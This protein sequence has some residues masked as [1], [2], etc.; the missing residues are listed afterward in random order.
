MRD[1]ATT[2]EAAIFR[3]IATAGFH[4][5]SFKRWE[6]ARELG[7][8]LP[9]ATAGLEG[10]TPKNGSYQTTIGTP[11]VHEQMIIVPDYEPCIDHSIHRALTG[12]G[13]FEGRLVR[14]A[15]AFKGYPWYDPVATISALQFTIEGGERSCSFSANEPIPDGLSTGCVDAISL[16]FAIG[17]DGSPPETHEMYEVPADL[18]IEQSAYYY[19]IDD[20]VILATG[21]CT[22]TPVALAALLDESCFSY[23][24]DHDADSWDS[25]HRA[26]EHAA[27][28]IANSL[29]LTEDEATLERIRAIWFEKLS[30]LIPQDRAVT[31]SASRSSFTIAF[32]PTADTQA[33][34]G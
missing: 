32:A 33:P 9:V 14:A 20:A 13:L 2:A 7:V 11:L 26:F 8:E 22:I 24:E 19:D 30:W 31:I 15:R 16:L 6:R 12:A 18:L 17:S 27:L 4:R 23:N 1:I 10:W 21:D 3:T 28:H 25:Q 34:A 29:L 5:L